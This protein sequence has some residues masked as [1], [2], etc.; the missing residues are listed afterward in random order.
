MKKRLYLLDNVKLLLIFLVILGHVIENF[1]TRNLIYKFIYVFHMPMFVLISGYTFKNYIISLNH[2]EIFKK[3]LFIYYFFQIFYYVLVN[4][5]INILSILMVPYRHLWFLFSLYCWSILVFFLQKRNKYKVIV[6]SFIASIA[7]GYVPFQLSFLSIGRTI[8]FFPFFLIG[9]HTTQQNFLRLKDNKTVTIIIFSLSL[10]VFLL[11]CQFIP[12][13]I[14][15]GT[16]SFSKISHS[17]LRLLLQLFSLVISKLIITIIPDVDFYF[18]KL[19]GLTLYIFIYHMLAI[20]VMNKFFDYINLDTH[21][22]NFVLSLISIFILTL[23]SSFII[24]IR[25][26]KSRL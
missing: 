5:N 8:V 23:L 10:L 24:L 2:K 3:T 21:F 7:V 4:R 6:F 18:T 12:N 1:T 11:S 22:N 16:R 17:F 25:K 20:E 9:F 19:G 14:L 26:L 13:E 15:W